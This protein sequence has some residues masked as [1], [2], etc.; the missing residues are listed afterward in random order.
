MFRSYLVGPK[1]HL[2]SQASLLV[3]GFLLKE[4]G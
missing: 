2:L 3:P 4:P 1:N